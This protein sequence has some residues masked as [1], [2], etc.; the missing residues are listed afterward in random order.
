LRYRALT[1]GELILLNRL[2]AEEQIR[3][4]IAIHTTRARMRPHALPRP[5]QNIVR[6][7]MA[8]IG[9]VGLA[10]HLALA[11]AQLDQRADTAA[12][13]VDKALQAGLSAV[14]GFEKQAIASLETDIGEFVKAVEHGS[15]S[16]K[17]GSG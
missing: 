8:R 3:R 2:R 10:K 14:D 15:N 9:F 17:N 11:H 7:D 12:D 16:L 5:A 13:K 4:A 6:E 1:L